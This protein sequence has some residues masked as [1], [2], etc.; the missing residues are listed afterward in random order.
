M[1]SF[2]EQTQCSICAL[3]QFRTKKNE[4]RRCRSALPERLPAAA[5]PVAVAQERVTG[6]PQNGLI[7]PLQETIRVAVLD[8]LD[9]CQ[10]N[11]VLAAKCLG[12][13]KTT[14]Y[15][16][17]RKWGRVSSCKQPAALINEHNETRPTISG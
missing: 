10:G 9:K 11:V 16:Y 8:A 5:H 7:Q 1:S 2:K 3:V 12:V 17:L 13:G 15:R 6:N 4:C 14:L